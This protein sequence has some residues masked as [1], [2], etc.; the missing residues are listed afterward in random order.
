[1]QRAGPETDSNKCLYLQFRYSEQIHCGPTD[2]LFPLETADLFLIM[3]CLTSIKDSIKTS[4]FTIQ[5]L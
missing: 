3:Y 1:M 4:L 2:F 5:Y